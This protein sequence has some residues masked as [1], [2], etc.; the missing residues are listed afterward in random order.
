MLLSHINHWDYGFRIPLGPPW[1]PSGLDLLDHIPQVPKEALWVSQIHNP[2]GYDNLPK[3]GGDLELMW[4]QMGREFSVL[5]EY[6]VIK[7]VKLTV[8][9]QGE[10]C[11]E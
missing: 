10:V 2:S 6:K 8:G 1:A 5:M 9:V 3:H 11:C 4:N 7:R